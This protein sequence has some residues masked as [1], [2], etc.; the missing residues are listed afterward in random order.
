MWTL[1]HILYTP[2]STAA[3]FVHVSYILIYTSYPP[4]PAV[5]MYHVFMVILHPYTKCPPYDTNLPQPQWPLPPDPETEVEMLLMLYWTGVCCCCCCWVFAK[6]VMS[7][8][9]IDLLSPAMLVTQTQ[10]LQS[11]QLYS[12]IMALN[13]PF[14]EIKIHSFLMKQG[15]KLW[16]DNTKITSISNCLLRLHRSFTPWNQRS[17]STFAEF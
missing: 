1:I 17:T 8:T 15:V 3:D 10:N 5:Y 7:D 9:A 11:I 12:I 14:L 16:I 4:S 2:P 6:M 13:L